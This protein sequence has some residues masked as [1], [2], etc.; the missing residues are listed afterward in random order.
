MS[1][2]KIKYYFQFF[3]FIVIHWYRNVLLWMYNIFVRPLDK[4]IDKYA[5]KEPIECEWIQVYSLI[6]CNCIN[7][8]DVEQFY[9]ES[10]EHNVFPYTNDFGCFITKEFDHL[11]ENNV[12]TPEYDNEYKQIPEVVE[13]LFIAHSHDNYI[14]R[15]LP[16]LF[17]KPCT[18]LK[19][20]ASNIEFIIVEYKHPN[21]KKSIELKLPK[22][23]YFVNNELFSPAFVQRQLQ[24]T[25]LYYVFDMNYQILLIDHEVITQQLSF[26]EYIILEKNSY[27]ICNTNYI[28]EEN[29][30]DTDDEQSDEY[31]KVP[32]EP[33]PMYLE[34][35][36][37]EEEYDT[38]IYHPILLQVMDFFSDFKF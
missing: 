14:F 20:E 37:F 11:I 1:F 30:I 36:D 34:L 24:L 4:M 26:N 3:T 29:K 2:M 5:K 7:N 27:K 32:N 6:T 13:T 35:E 9:F 12:K 31:E 16:T 22:G 21:M 19:Y 8:L 10:I 33:E 17:S 25:N 38:D 28:S 15:S 23:F 18:E